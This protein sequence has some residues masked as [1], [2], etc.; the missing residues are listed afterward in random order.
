MSRRSWPIVVGGCHRSGTT[1]VRR[2]LNAH[3]RI[4]CGPEV[5]FFRDFYADYPDDPLR[6][7]RFT[8]SARSILPEDELLGILGQAF[9]TV[10]ERAATRAGK[11]R[12]ADKAPEN[13]LYLDD[14]QRLLGEEWLFLNVVRNPLDTVASIKEAR[15]PLT[16]PLDLNGRIEFYTRYL[17]AGLRFA[18]AHPHRSFRVV[19]EDLCTNWEP[20]LAALM[21]FL[22]ETCESAQFAFNSSGHQQG[23]EDTKIATTSEIHADSVGRWPDVLTP[24]EAGAVWI[25]TRGL[26]SPASASAETPPADAG[27]LCQ[28]A[29]LGHQPA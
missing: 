9:V 19:Y 5:K 14:W 20:A 8:S 17:R 4:H 21:N 7:I 15:F 3:S 22:E 25:A 24:E 18:N 1:L 27:T 11:P 10:H 23:L 6:G 26:W 13:V 12:W 16:I 29:R 28:L 2:L